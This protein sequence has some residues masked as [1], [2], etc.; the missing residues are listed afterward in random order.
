MYMPP[1]VKAY[2]LASARP[3]EWK[4]VDWMAQELCRIF[5]KINPDR[6][7]ERDLLPI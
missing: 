6:L 7:S 3:G 2:G 1:C 4:H 5:W